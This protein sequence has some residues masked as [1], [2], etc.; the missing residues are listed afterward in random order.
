MW[1]RG[2]DSGISNG[3]CTGS[4]KC[5]VICLVLGK[6][7]PQLIN[8][9]ALEVGAITRSLWCKP[10]RDYCVGLGL[11]KR[12]ALIGELDIIKLPGKLG[13]WDVF[14]VAWACK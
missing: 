8:S 6:I 4:N 9:V 12:S 11:K 14:N 5:D 10:Q 3:G 13:L 1:V 7:I 2:F